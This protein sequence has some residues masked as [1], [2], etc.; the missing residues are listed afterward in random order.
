MRL[1][2]QLDDAV[3]RFAAGLQKLGVGEGDRVAIIDHGVIRE[4][5]AMKTLLA[6]LD[7]ETF[8]LDLREPMAEAPACEDMDIVLRD[9]N[10]LEVT[11]PKTKSVNALFGELDRLGIHV[12]SMR[13]KANRLEELFLRLVDK[14]EAA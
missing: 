11:L 10:T 3:D 2:G 8:V 4:N 5:T 14:G 9:E 7:V 13:N 6:K 12:I 1:Y